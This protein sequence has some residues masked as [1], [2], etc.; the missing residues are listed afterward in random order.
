MPKP[1]DI[2]NPELRGKVEAAFAAMRGGKRAE[3]VHALADAFTR[4]VEIYPAFLQ[5]TVAARGGRRISKLTRWPNLGA[6]MNPE[7]FRTGVPKIEF[8]R[9]SFATAEALTYY[10]FVIDEI[11]AQESGKS[12]GEGDG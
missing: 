10:Q 11:V 12:G 6:N 8:V 7:S 4:F 5:G 2:Q 3:A 9:E 1:T